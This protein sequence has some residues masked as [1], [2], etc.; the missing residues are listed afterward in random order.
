MQSFCLEHGDRQVQLGNVQSTNW[1]KD[2]LETDHH[3][4][5]K[6][7][8]VKQRFTTPDSKAG[9]EQYEMT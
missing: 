1:R 3:M 9:Y 8:L 5:E 2:R 6:N 7:Q 4:D